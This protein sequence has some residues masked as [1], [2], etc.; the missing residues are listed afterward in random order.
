MRRWAS[1]ARL[2]AKEKDQEKKEQTGEADPEPDPKVQGLKAKLHRVFA[3]GQNHAAK[4]VIRPNNPGFLPVHP[5][6]PAGIGGVGQ[7]QET[8][9][10]PADFE[11]HPVGFVA[12]S[13]ERRVGEE[14]RSRWS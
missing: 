14:G 8:L 12:R 13:E 5:G 2:E 6:P 1:G 11:F 9:A 4:S 3:P 7:D 10:R